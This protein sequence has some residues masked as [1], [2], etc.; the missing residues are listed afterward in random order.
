[1]IFRWLRNIYFAMSKPARP[2]SAKGR[3]RPV[4]GQRTSACRQGNETVQRYANL[5]QNVDFFSHFFMT[6]M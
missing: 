6:T 4:S 3:V 5:E 2:K 1:M